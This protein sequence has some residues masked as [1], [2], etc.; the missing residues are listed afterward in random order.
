M[1]KIQYLSIV[2]KKMVTISLLLTP[3]AMKHD[4]FKMK[5]TWKIS[6]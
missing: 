1:N 2:P 4:L 6:N 3:T 5:V